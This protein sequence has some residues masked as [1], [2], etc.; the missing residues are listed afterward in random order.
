LLNKYGKEIPRTWDEL[1][2]TARS[3]IKSEKEENPNIDLIGY[4][5]H[6][7]GMLINYQVLFYKKNNQHTKL[8]YKH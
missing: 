8:K 2:D 4:N 5:G 3:I 7:N 6:F 1:I